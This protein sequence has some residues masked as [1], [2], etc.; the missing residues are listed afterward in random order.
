MLRTFTP[1]LF[2]GIT[3]PI[4]AF[5]NAGA[6]NISSF[7]ASF[8]NTQELY[9][10]NSKLLSQVEEL[11]YENQKISTELSDIKALFEGE[12]PMEE[13]GILAGVYA[14]PPLSPYDSL[15]V[16]LPEGVSVE[17]EKLVLGP[18]GI[19]VGVVAENATSFATIILFSAPLKETQGWITEE[20]IPVTVTG[21]GGGMVSLRIP[22]EVSIKEGDMLYLGGPGALPAGSVVLITENLFENVSKVSVR[23]LV[24][25]FSISWVRIDT[26]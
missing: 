18:G 1:S 11:T 2:F 8:Y 25:P 19:P 23:L 22:D 12:V 21:E 7:F 20:K 3:A 26:L 15:L 17:K 14:R 13:A 16:L 9:N 6:Q 10:Q 24:N 4:F 5:G